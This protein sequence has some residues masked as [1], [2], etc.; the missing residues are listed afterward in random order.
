MS[1]ATVAVGATDRVVEAGR[2]H[3]DRD[4]HPRRAIGDEARHERRRVEHDGVAELLDRHQSP[5]PGRVGRCDRARRRLEL[6]R[7][8]GL[9]RHRRPPSQEHRDRVEEPAHAG[10]C[11]R[12]APREIEDFGDV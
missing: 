11:Q 1:A 6:D 12:R 8:L 4:R 7:G 3:R 2:E 5:V 10:R 9:V